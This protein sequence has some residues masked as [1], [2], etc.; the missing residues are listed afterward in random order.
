MTSSRR[1]FL[2]GDSAMRKTG[3]ILFAAAVIFGQ[4]PPVQMPGLPGVQ[5]PMSTLIPDA[6]Y[7]IDGSPDWLAAGEDPAGAPMVWTNSHP[8]HY[9]FRME[10]LTH[11]T[12]AQ[13]AAHKPRLPPPLARR[14]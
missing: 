5:H 6:E 10:P 11:N 9:V 13:I 14:L 3:L 2:S 12:V 4:Q 7:P 1:K 8:P